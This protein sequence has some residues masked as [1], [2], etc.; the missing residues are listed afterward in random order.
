MLAT[1]HRPLSVKTRRLTGDDTQTPTGDDTQ[2]PAGNDTQ[3]P[4]DDGNT[5]SA[6]NNTTAAQNNTNKPTNPQ[7]GDATVWFVIA[8]VAALGLAIVVKKIAAK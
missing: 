1:I 7:T 5:D 3:T 2:A 4:A 6:D 8:A